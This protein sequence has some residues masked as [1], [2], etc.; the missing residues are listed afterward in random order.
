M[1][2]VDMQT[3][4]EKRKRP[5]TSLLWGGTETNEKV[6]KKKLPEKFKRRHFPVQFERPILRKIR[7]VGTTSKTGSLE[8]GGPWGKWLTDGLGRIKEPSSAKSEWGLK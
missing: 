3:I 6:K 4:F 1:G 5:R 8:K 7:F 2:G